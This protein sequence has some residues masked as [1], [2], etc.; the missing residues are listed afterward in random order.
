MCFRC[1]LDAHFKESA[2]IKISH[3]E[4]KGSALCVNLGTAVSNNFSI[5]KKTNY[6][7]SQLALM[8]EEE[9]KNVILF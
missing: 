4:T 3:F 6:V 8:D 7:I 5:E 9:R 2:S 1:F